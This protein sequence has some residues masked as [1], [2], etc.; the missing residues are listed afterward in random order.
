VSK[1]DDSIL[2][3]AI[4]EDGGLPGGLSKSMMKALAGDPEIMGMLKDPK[5]Q[6]IMRDVMAKGPDGIKKHM[7]DPDALL[8]LQRLSAAMQKMDL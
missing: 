1:I 5:L 3:E 8:L 4:A 6:G 2:D 7:S